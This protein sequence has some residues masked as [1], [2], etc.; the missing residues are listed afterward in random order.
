MKRIKLML[1]TVVTTLLLNV[2]NINAQEKST[3]II[4]GN[5]WVTAKKQYEIQIVKP[6]YE[7]EIKDYQ[8]VD[9][10]SALKKE[11]DYWINQGYKLTGSTSNSL[12]QVS[13]R[14]IFILIKEE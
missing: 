2:G 1:A 9:L 13:E 3:V 6:N 7:T 4:T 10:F 11:I 14:I 8:G 12:S 5:T